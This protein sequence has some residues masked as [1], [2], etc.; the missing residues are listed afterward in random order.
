MS[1]SEYDRNLSKNNTFANT[2]IT[3][4]LDIRA[5]IWA[6]KLRVS[7]SKLMVQ[8]LEYVLDRLDKGEISLDSRQKVELKDVL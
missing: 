6:G 2:V 3:T 5:R 4:E 1:G 8:A 7:R